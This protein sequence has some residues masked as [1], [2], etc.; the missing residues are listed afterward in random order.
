[1]P[2]PCFLAG[3]RLM[4]LRGEVPVETVT[5]GDSVVTLTGVGSTLKPV[6]A[7]GKSLVDLDRHPSPLDAAPVRLR[8][9]AVE[10][11]IPVRDLLVSPNHGIALEDDRGRKMLIPA[12]YLVNGATIRREPPTGIVAYHHIALDAHDILMADGIA[13]ESNPDETA[14]QPARI[15]PFC[16]PRPP[17]D[18][19]PCFL[20]AHRDPPG[21]VPTLLGTA[22]HP[23]HARLLEA[24]FASGHQLTHDPGLT[25]TTN[26]TPA[27]L[28]S[29]D[30]GEYLFLLPPD[31]TTIR[32]HSRTTIPS[33]TR[34]EGGDSRRLGV[35]LKAILHDGAILPLNGPHCGPGFLPTEPAWRWT[36][37]DAELTLAPRPH[38]TTLELHL[39]TGWAHYW[40][41][42]P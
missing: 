15:V 39:A 26:G 37:G 11:G 13:A 19:A 4:T 40:F 33:D 35:A 3:A 23:F 28:V 31:A 22:A 20:P 30:S 9:G 17:E 16:R 32:L 7:V 41:E 1:M 10:P 42:T 5:P 2:P 38:E 12:L 29:A 27:E 25:V 36:T 24:A 14:E 34:P 6:A 21:C 18:L 8:A